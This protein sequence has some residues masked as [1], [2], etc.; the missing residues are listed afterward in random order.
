MHCKI[1]WAIFYKSGS[2]HHTSFLQPFSPYHYT[3]KPTKWPVRP[4]KTQTSL[5]IRP[6][7]S[8]FCCPYENTWSL[9]YPL[10]PLSAQRRLRSDW[11]ESSLGARH[12]VGFVV[13]WL[14]D[15]HHLRMV[16]TKTYMSRD[17][18]KTT[19]CVCAQRRLRSACASAQS[20]QSLRCALS[21]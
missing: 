5:G 9:S 19:K 18:T 6:V 1:V 13:Q 15:N 7:W 3:T 17:M 12:F 10:T 14:H 16:N 4:A 2:A 8:E 20:D 11:S 21:G